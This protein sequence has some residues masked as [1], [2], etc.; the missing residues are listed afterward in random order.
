MKHRL[1][2]LGVIA[3]AALAFASDEPKPGQEWTE[4]KAAQNS[5]K[6]MPIR[7]TRAGGGPGKG[8]YAR[9]Y[10]LDLPRDKVRVTEEDSNIATSVRVNDTL[11]LELQKDPKGLPSAV[12]VVMNKT[13]YHD[14][15]CDGVWDAWD[16]MRDGNLKRFISHKGQWVQVCDFVGSFFNGARE[17]LSLDRKT[18][19]AWDGKVWN[20]RPPKR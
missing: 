2:A 19:Y 18:K 15:D 12:S 3:L 20:A 8:G 7:V 14:L 17:V 13:A 9:N 16:D 6:M 1:L 10:Y 4:D 5:S 11:G